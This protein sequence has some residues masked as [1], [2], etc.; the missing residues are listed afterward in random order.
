MCNHFFLHVNYL[1]Q[2]RNYPFHYK[3]K[4]VFL[5]KITDFISTFH[6]SSRF[7]ISGF[8]Y[9][10]LTC[11]KQL[12]G[13]KPLIFS[14]WRIA[15]YSHSRVFILHESQNKL[16]AVFEPKIIPCNRAGRVG[17]GFESDGSGSGSSQT[18]RVSLTF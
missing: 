14:Y 11:V 4:N 5:R 9:S 10:E 8:Q 13:L 12:Q 16:T 1:Q 6:K 18:S 3:T 17:F 2:E 15:V 7:D